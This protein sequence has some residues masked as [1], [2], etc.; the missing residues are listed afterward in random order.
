MEENHRKKY[1]RYNKYFLLMII[2]FTERDKLP[3]SYPNKGLNKMT[4]NDIVTEDETCVNI[5]KMQSSNLN[6]RW[7]TNIAKSGQ[8]TYFF[9]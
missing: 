9:S 8:R 4:I 1:L 6:L 5:F 2:L 7:I 3:I